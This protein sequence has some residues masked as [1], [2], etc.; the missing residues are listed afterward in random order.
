[1]DDLIYNQHKIPAHQWRYGFRR[2][3]ATGCGWIATYNAL[4]LLG[5]HAQPENLIRYYERQLPLIHGN[6]GTSIWGP[7]VCFRQWGFPTRMVLRRSR[8]DD[9]VKGSDVSILFYRWR[10]GWRIGAHFVAVHH[11][12]QGFVGYN[13]FRNSVGPDFYGESLD[14]FLRRNGYFG[15]AVTTIS[16]RR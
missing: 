6:L 13:T 15:A 5:H 1:M 9:A 3:S 7:A 2:S 10:R 11:T 4:H 14:D 16:H 8:F 12:P